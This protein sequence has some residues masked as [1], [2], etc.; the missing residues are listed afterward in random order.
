M[1]AQAGPACDQAGLERLEVIRRNKYGA[2][3]TPCQH[4]HMHDSMRE[5]V[6]CNDL[7]LL[8][9]AGKIAMLQVQ[10][11]LYFVVDGKPLKLKNG[12]RAGMKVDFMYCELPSLK[13]VAEDSKGY[14]VRDYPLRSALFRHC[15]PMLELR[16]V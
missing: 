11:Q 3:K 5:A 16:E 4:G 7:H 1:E 8:Q 9:R 12:R 13:D 14:T 10:H 2:R 6:R 15:F